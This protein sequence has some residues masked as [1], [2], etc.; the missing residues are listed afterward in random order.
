MKNFI[1][2][3]MK[4]FGKIPKNK[5]IN[6]FCNKTSK[7]FFTGDDSLSIEVKQHI[8]K[9]TIN[10]EARTVLKEAVNN[11]E[12]LVDFIKAKG[13]EVVKSNY[14][15]SVL[16][17][18]GE[19]E[20]FLTPMKG[21]KSFIFI[22]FVNM[23]SGTKLKISFSTP[24]LFA[25]DNKPVNIY[26][27]SHQFHL[28]LSYINELPGFSESTRKNFKNIWNS[29]AGSVELSSLSMED[30]LSLKDAI[31]RDLEAI[32]FVKDMAREFVGQK[33]SLEKIKQGKR[34]NI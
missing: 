32:K 6:K 12:I 28:W 4:K 21:L 26:L 25:F 22:V 19:Q 9:E 30:I 31:A 15:S 14:M 11:P 23:F 17:L 34:V 27:L 33:Q 16:F 3:I 8:L 24:A 20:G 13:T 7:Q 10:D 2:L 1:E 18:L 5:L 29:N